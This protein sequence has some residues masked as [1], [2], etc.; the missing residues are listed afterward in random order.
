MKRGAVLINVARGLVVREAALVEA[1]QSGQ[2]AGAG[3]D[4]TEVEPL[5]PSS[6]LWDL[7]NI[8]I[9][10]HVGAQAAYRA[11]DTTNLI[12]ENL[13]RYLAGEPLYNLV[14]KR[15]GFPEPGVARWRKRD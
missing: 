4:V 3:L 7:P 15:L 5:P 6:E 14:D 9:T 10:P 12:A 8:I 11:D 13:R 1:L 2:L